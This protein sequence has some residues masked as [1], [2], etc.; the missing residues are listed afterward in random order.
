M[1]RQDTNRPLLER[2]VEQS[3]SASSS[4]SEK[5]LLSVAH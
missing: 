5:R 1:M 2:M 4:S 3:S